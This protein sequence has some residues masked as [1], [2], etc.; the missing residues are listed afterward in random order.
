MSKSAKNMKL[1]K[2]WIRGHINK[3]NCSSLLQTK[4]AQELMALSKALRKGLINEGTA[5]GQTITLL[6]LFLGHTC[7][8]LEIT[9]PSSQVGIDQTDVLL[10][11][12]FKVETFPLQLQYLSIFWHFGE[13][14]IARYDS[15]TKGSTSRFVIDEQK[16]KQGDASLTIQNVTISLQGTYT[17]T[18]I[19]ILDSE[20]KSLQLRILA[21][22]TVSLKA[23]STP[24]GKDGI[25]VCEATKFFPEEV[26]MRWLLD[27]KRID[28]SKQ[29]NRYF[30]KEIYHQIQNKENNPPS[31]IS[32]EVQHEALKS[33]IKMTEEVKLERDC[34]RRW[35]FVIIGV[36]VVLLV[37]SLPGLWYFM[38]R[39]S[40]RF[41]V[42]HIHRLRTE[43]KVNFYCTASN[44]PQDVR[45]T[46]KIQENNG[47][48]ILISANNQERDEEAAL[49]VRSDYTVETELSQED[50]LHHAISALSFTPVVS[51][52]KEIEVS[53]RFF[54]NRRSLEKRLKWSFN[55]KKVELSVSGQMSLGDNGDVL[56]SVSLQNF[57]PKDIE[58]KWSHGLGPFQEV[59]TFQETFTKNNDFTFNV[60]SV[61]RVPGRLFKDQGYR[62]R[63]A[64]CHGTETGQQEVSITDSDWRPVMGE[65]EK[66]DFIDG[67]EAKLLCRVS[68][69]YPDVLDVRW[70]R[71]DA[72]SQEFQILS[73]NDKYKIPV[74]EATQ[75]EDK[76]F[77]YTAGLMVSV[78]AA[79]DY[80]AEF[81]CR[82]RHPSLK[83]PLEKRTGEIRV[84]EIRE[85]ETTSPA[86][87]RII[88]RKT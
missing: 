54:C 5:M 69:Y 55:F 4:S 49:K 21:A 26:T 75:Q 45:V 39:D 59:E 50:K 62:V 18:V 66:P 46:W 30:H 88:K 41:Q 52:H 31:Q 56:C 73:A 83:T 16:V 86:M 67:K 1:S 60:R 65:I 24:D 7:C 37:T 76:T 12:T 82:V 36:L 74:M 70:L 33:P 28:S 77:T 10:P 32:C 22:P 15:K 11:C 27:G 47:E 81:I 64:W 19:Y 8:A 71:R 80:G 6:L 85:E 34:N 68:G 42:G 72:E 78:S 40:Q 13:N 84:M 57:Y 9:V 44:C 2:G 25:Y 61:C 35:H 14:K 79:T 63:A 58:L 3:G 20:A 23:A 53:C 17:C 48:M 51:K 29:S 38:K 87:K 43:E